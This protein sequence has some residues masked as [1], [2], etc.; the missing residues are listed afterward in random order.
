MKCRN[1]LLTT[2]DRIQLPSNGTF[3]SR[4][5]YR[6]EIQNGPSFT[7]NMCI[8]QFTHKIPTMKWLTY[9]EI[10]QRMASL[11]GPEPKFVFEHTTTLF[12]LREQNSKQSKQGMSFHE[13][14]TD[15][16]GFIDQNVN[17]KLIMCANLAEWQVKS[18]YNEFVL[19]CYP[20]SWMTQS[21]LARF[22]HQKLLVPMLSEEKISKYFRLIIINYHFQYYN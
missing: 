4:F 17:N 2:I 6:I 20:S 16:N 8:C 12:L 13:Y 18:L 11:A 1:L 3:V 19:H 10:R 5:I 7:G 15:K 21:S 9:S 14:D 22:F